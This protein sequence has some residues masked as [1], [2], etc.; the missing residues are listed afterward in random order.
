MYFPK[1]QTLRI[2]ILFRKFL[3]YLLIFALVVEVTSC[4]IFRGSK[5]KEI[6]IMSEK[7]TTLAR[8]YTGVPYRSG[9]NDYSGIDCSG[10]LC[11]VFKEIGMKIPRVS[12]QQAEFFPDITKKE[13]QQ[14]DLVFFITNDGGNINHAGI[15]T[16]VK[17]DDQIY[18][19]SA[20]TSRGVVEDNLFSNYWKSKLAKITRPV[21]ENKFVFK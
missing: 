14:G 4:N 10:L 17:G 16:E 19:I 15:V 5:K 6:N 1:I 9:G 2:V 21:F 12:W 13:M 8:T 18:F 11:N 20:T 3:Q 7:I